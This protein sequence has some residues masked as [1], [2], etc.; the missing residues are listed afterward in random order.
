ML[1]VAKKPWSRWFVILLL[2]FVAA[3]LAGLVRP[4]GLK[5]F[6]VAGFPVPFAAWGLG[7]EDS[8]DWQA[9]A[10]DTTLAI[11]ISAALAWLCSLRRPSR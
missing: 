1:T 7:I 4:M 2:G 10:V 3:N 8:F 9:L 5:R 11:A 6:R